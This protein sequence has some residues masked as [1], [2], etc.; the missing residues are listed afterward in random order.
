MNRR[1][2][3][4]N[5]L[6]TSMAVSA[7][8]AFGFPTYTRSSARDLKI[9]I[10]WGTIGTGETIMEKFEISKKAGFDG[11]QVSS[12]LDRKKVLE[13]SKVTEVDISGVVGSKHW[14]F[15]LSSPDKEVRKKGVEALRVCLEDAHT[16]GC[17]TVLFVPGKVNKTASYDQCWNHSIKEIKKVIPLAEK[18]KVTIA[19]ENVWNNFLLSPIEANYYLDQFK[20]PYLKFYFDCGNIL[21]YGWP[22]QWIKILGDRIAR[23]HIKEFS[24][25]VANKQ[26]KWAGFK[27]KLGEGD[28]NWPAVM[29]ALDDIRYTGWVTLEQGGG[30]S[31]EGLTDL[32]TRTKKIINS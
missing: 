15:P 11:I 30:D 20:S 18:L 29:K 8:S 23:V 27:S 5:T 9:S 22:E 4:K 32:V 25:K 24:N 13:A 10:M 21:M 28:V 16:Y 26:G 31:L 2:F 19:I 6:M 12:H 3:V 14:E 1:K 7:T 17:D